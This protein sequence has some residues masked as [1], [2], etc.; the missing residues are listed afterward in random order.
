AKWDRRLTLSAK[1]IQRHNS[2]H[3]RTHN[4]LA[5]P[6]AP[7][8]E[9]QGLKYWVR[10]F[11]EPTQR[12]LCDFCRTHVDRG[13]VL[14]RAR[15]EASASKASTTVQLLIQYRHISDAHSSW[16]SKQSVEPE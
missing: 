7:G 6:R 4:S 15:G 12:Q 11:I 9:S 14:L 8:G 1:P 16:Q 10:Y 5:P 2:R 3:G 13:A